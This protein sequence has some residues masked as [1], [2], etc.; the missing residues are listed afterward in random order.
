MK[1]LLIKLIE[2]TRE[3]QKQTYTPPIGLWSIRSNADAEVRILDM[4]LAAKNGESHAYGELIC[5]LVDFR[6]EAVGLSA[7]FSI[8]DAQYRIVS[9]IVRNV[10]P[11][12]SIAA[13]GFHASAID[14]LPGVS[15]CH[16]EGEPFFNKAR[17]EYAEYQDPGFET[18]EIKPYWEINRPHD[19][20]SKT[21]RWM[22][23]E[24]SRG[25][26]RA[27]EFCGV[28]NFWGK[29]RGKGI[30]QI[31]GY[32]RYL[33]E[34]GVQEIFIEDDNI[35]VDPDRFL[36]L[37]SLFR[38][39]GMWWSCP[40]GIEINSIADWI[41]DINRPLSSS[42]CWRLSLPF[43]TGCESTAELMRL[44]SKWIPFD[45]AR[46]IVEELQDEGILTC[47]FFIIG[48]PGET[49]CDMQQTLDYA[50]ALPLDQRNIYITTPYP[51]TPLYDRCKR[52]G[53]LV[54]DGEDLYKNLLYTK[55]QIHTDDFTPE[56]VEELK[57]E[58][59]RQAIERPPVKQR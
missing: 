19:L 59:R 37:M 13:G 50:N 48:Y 28:R 38:D 11:G 31:D 6:P 23:I 8:Q 14:P 56:Q 40:N 18:A 43:E 39:H 10:C 9:G 34:R 7:Q 45:H 51:G 44:D 41:G 46:L 36:V 21:D 55:S 24:T 58:D 26:I 42:K 33:I 54:S 25:C 52:D 3:T 29:W 49:L 35:A 12:V 1:L 17:G 15:V 47:G 5:T 53:Y 20:Q 2:P 4:H 16:G 22:P 27:C 32:L 30:D 57:Q